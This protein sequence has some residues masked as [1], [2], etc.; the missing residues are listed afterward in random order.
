DGPGGRC[1]LRVGV[2]FRLPAELPPGRHEVVVCNDPCTM[3]IG[4]ILASSIYV[5]VDPPEPIVREWPLDEPAIRWLD[6]DA[7]V[8]GSP[9]S[10]PAVTAADVRAGRIVAPTPPREPATTPAPP[11][12]DQATSTPAPGDQA[13]PAVPQGRGGSP[14]DDATRATGG[15]QP[16]GGIGAWVSQA[17]AGTALVLG[18]VW[19]WWLR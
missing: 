15:D 1:S 17:I 19:L 5:G 12:A 4:E 9:P 2:E 8:L 3:T 13:T 18:L 6:G 14:L 16:G 7:L 10:S 11:P